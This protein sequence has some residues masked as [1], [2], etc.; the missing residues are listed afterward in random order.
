MCYF[1]VYFF[2]GNILGFVLFGKK[3]FRGWF[4]VFILE[5]GIL[6]LEF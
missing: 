5:V 6:E 4:F 1:G 3:G 2:E